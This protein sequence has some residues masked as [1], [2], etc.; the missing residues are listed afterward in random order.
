MFA[1][2]F[3]VPDAGDRPRWLA[4]V[5]HL[6]GLG[7]TK[8]FT[9]ARQEASERFPASLRTDWLV[10]SYRCDPSPAAVVLRLFAFDVPLARDV[11][12]KALGEAWFEFAVGKGIVVEIEGG[13]LSPFQL[14]MVNELY[15]FADRAGVGRDT[16]MALGPTTEV[17]ARASYPQ[18][19]IE[20]ALDLGCGCGVL[21]LL[22]ARVA[23][24]VVGTD[25]NPRAIAMARLNAA[26]NGVENVS[27]RY[28]DLFAPVE[29]ERFELIVSQPPFLACADGDISVF[30]LH[31][32]SRGDELTR[33]I[34]AEMPDY[35]AENGTGFVLADFGLGAEERIAERLPAAGRVTILQAP[36]PVDLEVNA[37]LYIA[38]G[39][40][41]SGEPLWEET[42]RQVAHYRAC[43]VDHLAPALLVV[44]ACGDGVRELSLGPEK[45]GELERSLIDPLVF[46]ARGLDEPWQVWL[47]RRLRIVDG[48]VIH[49]E[50][51]FAAS[52]GGRI[53]MRS[54][55]GSLLPDPVVGESVLSFLHAVHKADT[56]ADALEGQSGEAVGSVLARL[57]LH[58]ILRI[59]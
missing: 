38:N 55:S 52:E 24:R 49:R 59:C 3:P 33:R 51:P 20:S 22:L 44:E 23:G 45:W 29:G 9:L 15:L 8:D 2:L 25:L 7:L 42:A 17:L 36:R 56:V 43:G 28:G 30:F 10:N 47:T 14:Q 13:W 57:V 6:R 35:L 39:R 21:A 1:S 27:F 11:A 46:A 53:V 5:H 54:G 37:A 32:G 48:T 26:M 18:S 34:L 50:S 58:R 16:V 40:F 19:D 31:G 41:L 4:F 12:A